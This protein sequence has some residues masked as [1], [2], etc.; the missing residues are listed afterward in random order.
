MEKAKVWL[1]IVLV[2]FGL[3]CIF[4]VFAADADFTMTVPNGW[5]QRTKST[6]LAQYQK[7]PRSFI[8]TADAMPQNANSPDTYVAF[9]KEQLGKAFKTIAYEPVVA[10][11]I[12]GHDT[13]ELK[14]TV[15]TSGIKMKYDVLYVFNKGKAYT[16]MAATM[17]DFYD[18]AFAADIKA[19]FTSFKFK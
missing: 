1:T 2:V 13:R 10:G 3:G 15:D 19:F 18:A 11:K 12:D 5:T 9:V 14:Y 17:A 7:G 6:A 4:P 16:L 8:V